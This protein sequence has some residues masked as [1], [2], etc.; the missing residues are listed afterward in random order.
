MLGSSLGDPKFAIG[1]VY[2][3]VLPYKVIG[4]ACCCTAAALLY[5]CVVYFTCQ[6]VS[7]QR[8]LTLNPTSHPYE[9]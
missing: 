5:L 7:V 2:L 1:L 3:R 9:F 8:M 6:T 4:E